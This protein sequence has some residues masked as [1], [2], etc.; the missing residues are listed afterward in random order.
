L[1]AVDCLIVVE[2]KWHC[3][4]GQI[5]IVFDCLGSCDCLVFVFI[6]TKLFVH[7]SQTLIVFDCLLGL[8]MFMVYVYGVRVASVKGQLKKSIKKWENFNLF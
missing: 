7:W 4:W 1:I 3:H 8:C 6:G 5:L 2:M